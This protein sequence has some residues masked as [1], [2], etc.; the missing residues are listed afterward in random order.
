MGGVDFLLTIDFT[1]LKPD[2]FNFPYAFLHICGPPGGGH[3]RE[4]TVSSACGLACGLEWEPGN[5]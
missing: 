4:C 3:S 2:S 5:R 1:V